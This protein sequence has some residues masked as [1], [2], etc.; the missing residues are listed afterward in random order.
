[1]NDTRTNILDV[2]EDLIQRVGL[3]A[4]SYK[5]ISEAIGI[6]KASIH[7][8]FPKKENLIDELLRRCHVS[9]GYN[10]QNIVE[11]PGSAPQKLRN[12]ADVFAQG[13]RSQKLCLVGTISSDLNTLQ[14]SSCSILEK[15]IQGT[16]DIFAVA[17]AQGRKDGTLS[18][19]GTIEDTASAFFSLLLGAQLAARAYGGVELFRRATEAMISCLEK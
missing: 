10:Y 7:H 13:L 8:H 4:M 9:Y 12:L 16:V 3:N 6:S 15:T 11:G 17:F 19:P 1:M 18:F 14:G 5:H 2:A